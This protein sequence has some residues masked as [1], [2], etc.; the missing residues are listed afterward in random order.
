MWCHDGMAFP[1]VCPMVMGCLVGS[2]FE[3]PM[4][5]PRIVPRGHHLVCRASMEQP[6]GPSVWCPM[7]VTT[8]NINPGIPR[9]RTVS[10]HGMCYGTCTMGPTVGNTTAFSVAR[11]MRDYGIGLGVS[12]VAMA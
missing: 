12:W 10:F 7:N 9:A 6:T 5:G 8:N 1:M 11:D 4:N 2:T 3:Y